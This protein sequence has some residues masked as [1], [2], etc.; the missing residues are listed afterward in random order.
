MAKS[1][2]ELG[3]TKRDKRNILITLF[4]IGVITLVVGVIEIIQGTPGALSF[5]IGVIS[6]AMWLFCSVLFF[7]NMG[8]YLMNS[9]DDSSS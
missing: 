7:I 3:K 1:S 9:N 8:G 2:L 5:T 4:V 6:L